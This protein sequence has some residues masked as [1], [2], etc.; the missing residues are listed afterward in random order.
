MM[1]AKTGTPASSRNTA[2]LSQL[3]S[4]GSLLVST[5]DSGSALAYAGNA[6]PS[7]LTSSSAASSG[8][9]WNRRMGTSWEWVTMT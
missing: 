9:A 5:S 8:R 2:A 7:D 3:S 4:S 1:T 6:A